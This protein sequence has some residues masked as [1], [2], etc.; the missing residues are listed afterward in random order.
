MSPTRP[1][2]VH[3]PAILIVEDDRESS[4]IYADYLESKGFRV[5]LTRDAYEGLRL[6]R[7][8]MPALI[9]MDLQLPFVG[10]AHAIRELKSRP[11][12]RDIPIVAMTA[13]GLEADR[14]EARSAG[15]DDFLEKPCRP[16]ELLRAVDLLLGDPFSGA[17]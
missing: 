10:G 13:S 9:L 5:L 6:A 12:T 17:G 16:P 4:T 14:Q 2:S 8:E 15:C 11:D 1:R 7:M 3:P